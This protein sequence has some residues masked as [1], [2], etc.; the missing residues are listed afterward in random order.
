[1]N[2][3]D[4]IATP[5]DLVEMNKKAEEVTAA[6]KAVEALEDCNYLESKAIIEWLLSNII[7]FHQESAIT[8]LNSDTPADSIQWIEDVKAYTIAKGIIEGIA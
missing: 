7:T 4:T 6:Q 1:M 8:A 2:N 5:A 3:F